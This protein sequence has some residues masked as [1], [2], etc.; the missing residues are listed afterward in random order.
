MSFGVELSP[1]VLNPQEVETRGAQVWS[2]ENQ[3]H[4]NGTVASYRIQP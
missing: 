2:V 4:K 1:P 3:F